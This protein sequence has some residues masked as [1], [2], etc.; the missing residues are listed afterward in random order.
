M[1]D[2]E[3]IVKA[4]NTRQVMVNLLGTHPIKTI[5]ENIVK[6]LTPRLTAK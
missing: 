4:M 6:T 1:V 2:H 3:Q 5:L